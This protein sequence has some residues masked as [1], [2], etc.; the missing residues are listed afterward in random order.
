MKSYFLLDFNDFL[1]ESA[2]FA[3]LK[4][5]FLAYRAGRLNPCIFPLLPKI[6]LLKF[7][8]LDIFISQFHEFRG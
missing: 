4:F 8:L 7:E 3:F 2:Q 6:S 5:A 1:W